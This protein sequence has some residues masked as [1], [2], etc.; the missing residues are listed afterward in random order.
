[1]SDQ[2]YFCH[3]D[4][5]SFPY[6]VSI[7]N[8]SSAGGYFWAFPVSFRICI[9]IVHVQSSVLWNQKLP[10][11]FGGFSIESAGEINSGDQIILGLYSI[12]N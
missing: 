8:E 5:L 7:A 4:T 1:M 9:S 10:F 2:L 3:F 6:L 12:A 11:R